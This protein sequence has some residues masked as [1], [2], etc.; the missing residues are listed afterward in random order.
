MTVSPWTKSKCSCGRLL[1]LAKPEG[2]K[3][4]KEEMI[5]S[6][7]WKLARTVHYADAKGDTRFPQTPMRVR[8]GTWAT[9]DS[10]R[11]WKYLSAGM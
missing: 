8:I 9:G 4:K 1:D 10:V 5:F 7:R 6:D 2:E 11:E 3:E